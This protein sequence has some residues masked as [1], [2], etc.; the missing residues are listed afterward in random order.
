MRRLIFF[1]AGFGGISDQDLRISENSGT[2]DRREKA[3]GK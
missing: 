2:N 3:P 1:S